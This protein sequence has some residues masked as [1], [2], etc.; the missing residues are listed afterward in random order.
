MALRNQI[1]ALAETFTEGII[2]AIR[3]ASLEEILAGELPAKRGPG[4][5]LT[6]RPRERSEAAPQPR[7]AQRD[8]PFTTSVA[9]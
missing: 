9:C 6:T 8:D 7:R 4:R 2:A 3:S 1:Q 5:P